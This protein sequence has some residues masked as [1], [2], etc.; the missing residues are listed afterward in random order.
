MKMTRFKCTDQLGNVAYIHH[1]N[2]RGWCCT[3]ANGIPASMFYA[4]GNCDEMG[5]KFKLEDAG[6]DKE[7]LSLIK[8]AASPQTRVEMV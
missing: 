3:L 2:A 6:D 4:V 7:R 1:N 8:S 5:L